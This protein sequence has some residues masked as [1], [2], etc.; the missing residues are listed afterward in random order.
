MAAIVPWRKL[1]GG[2]TAGNA[3][4]L[5]S[6]IHDVINN[7]VSA[8]PTLALWETA[9]YTTNA[10]LILRPH[11][12][13]SGVAASARIALFG[14]SAPNATA[15]PGLTTN[16]GYLYICYGPTA[17]VNTPDNAF[18]A[19]PLFTTGLYLT[20]ILSVAFAGVSAVEV[21]Q[22]D[23]GCAFVPRITTPGGTAGNVFFGCAGDLMLEQDALTAAP[24]IFGGGAGLAVECMGIAPAAGMLET[25]ST[26]GRGQ[27][28]LST[29]VG[30]VEV[31]R[32]ISISF[33]QQPGLVDGTRYKFLPIPM[34]NISSPSLHGYMR[35]MALGPSSGLLQ[36]ITSA[37]SAPDP[38]AIAI[39]TSNI[40]GSTLWLTN[41][42]V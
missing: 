32:A 20:S 6:A 3:A 10:T 5:I 21:V 41:F 23:A 16:S 4:A 15:V 26:G 9:Y 11:A 2:A 29:D 14:G 17:G 13:N 25:G 19:G 35:Q 31:S 24:Y 37:I 8:N 36:Q 7:D 33:A 39:S 28:K 38:A 27:T 42:Q 34:R 18:T 12:N 1:S 40:S 30:I 22:C